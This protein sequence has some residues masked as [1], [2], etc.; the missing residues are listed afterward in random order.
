MW[1]FLLSPFYWWR[2]WGMEWLRNLSKAHGWQGKKPC[3]TWTQVASP[4]TQPSAPFSFPS[5]GHMAPGC[6][7]S[8]LLEETTAATCG[9]SALSPVWPVHTRPGQTLSGWDLVALSS[10]CSLR[11]LCSEGEAA[12]FRAARWQ[13]HW[14][15]LDCTESAYLKSHYPGT[16]KPV[17]TLSSPVAPPSTD[18]LPP[19]AAYMDEG[20]WVGAHRCW[21]PADT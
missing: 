11:T 8:W 19:I 17:A 14:G 1:L 12:A 20:S 18:T 21:A 9:A 5:C 2:N 15:G 13:R 7:Y 4:C 16:W 3:V 6:Y 10:G